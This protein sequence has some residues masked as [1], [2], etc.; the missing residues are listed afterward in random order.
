MSFTRHR[1]TSALKLLAAMLLLT[2]CKERSDHDA[3]GPQIAEDRYAYEAQRGISL[4]FLKAT[5]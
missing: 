4:T 5:P 3:L 1:T 2:T